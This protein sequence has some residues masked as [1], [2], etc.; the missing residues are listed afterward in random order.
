MNHSLISIITPSF[1]RAAMIADAVESVLAQA[2]PNFE[3]IIVDGASTDGTLDVLN[4]YPHL[5]LLSEPDRGMYDAINKGLALAHG[6]IVAW[7]NTDDLYPPGTFAAVTDAFAARP[8]ALAISG[9]AETFADSA[10]GPRVLKTDQ[11][12]DDS[13]F[14]RRIVEAPVPN[15]WFFKKSLFEKI[16]N[17]DPSYRFV[18]DREFLIRV[19]LAGIRPVS[20]ARTLYRY[21]L[22][23]GSATFHAEDSRHPVYGPRRMEVNREDLRMVESFLVRSDLPRQV[24]GV[25]VR[26]HSEYA[27]R[28]AA[29]ALYHRRWDLVSEGV[30]AGLRRDPLFPLA[31]A[32]FALRRTFKGIA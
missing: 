2:Y 13:D 10:D 5:R 4:K 23:E 27:Y 3:H 22:H 21:R 26:A 7:L 8:D 31:F 12:M 20:V 29:T 18:A 25:M 24:R 11:A 30:R 1:N 17:F 19:A 28:L 16:G 15:G 32:R 6:D 9:A 14:W